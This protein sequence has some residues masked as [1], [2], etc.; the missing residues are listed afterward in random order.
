VKKTLRFRWRLP[1]LGF[2]LLLPVAGAIANTATQP[3]PRDPAWLQRHEDFVR[4]ARQGDIDVLFLGDSIT[5][6]WRKDTFL[7]YARGRAVWDK[8]FAPLGA[9]NF[10]ISGDRTQHVLWRIEHGELTGIHPK[11]VVLMIGT[12]NTGTETDGAIRN[13]TPEVIAGVTAVVREIRAR[14]PRSRILLL[15][16][17]PRGKKSDPRRAQVA[18][19]NAAIATLDDGSHIHFL[20]IGASFLE[21]D[22]TLPA[23]IMP[24][25]LHPN[26]KGYQIWAEAIQGPLNALLKA[27]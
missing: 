25:L 21:P 13:T 20:D 27:N 23:S 18:E 12:N 6:F 24:D 2:A 14:L 5:D 22:G 16:I 11:V 4:I 8:Y 3:A 1:A 10:G 19:V 15:G 9:A 17:F 26:E 7:G